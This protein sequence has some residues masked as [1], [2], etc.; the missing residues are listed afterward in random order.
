MSSAV[1]QPAEGGRLPRDEWV[2][3][4]EGDTRKVGLPSAVAE[5]DLRREGAG[6][7]MGER[8]GCSK[9]CSVRASRDAGDGSEEA[10]S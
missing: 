4:V 3:R 7:T 5:L 1:A 9:K 2:G 6:G 10:S 8:P